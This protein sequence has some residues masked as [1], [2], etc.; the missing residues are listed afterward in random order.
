MPVKCPSPCSEMNVSLI[1][2]LLVGCHVA[3]RLL[4]IYAIALGELVANPLGDVLGCGV[5]GKHLV[6]VRMVQLRLDA[7]LD[8]LGLSADKIAETVAEGLSDET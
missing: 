4:H 3:L 8:E 5:A 1:F 2:I 6:E 7:L